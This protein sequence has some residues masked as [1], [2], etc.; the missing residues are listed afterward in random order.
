MIEMPDKTPVYFREE[1]PNCKTP[2]WHCLSRIDPKTYL[3][4]DFL[5]EFEI[6]AE[7]KTINKRT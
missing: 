7:T 6:D 5:R 1:C 4:P 3:E 2:V